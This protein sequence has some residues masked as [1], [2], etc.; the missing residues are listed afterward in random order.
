MEK[1]YP[2]YE[3]TGKTFFI[4]GAMVDMA[5]NMSSGESNSSNSKSNISTPFTL[6]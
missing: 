6:V 2:L 5:I 4:G 1:I 3:F